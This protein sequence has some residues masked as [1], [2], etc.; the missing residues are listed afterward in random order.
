MTGPEESRYDERSEMLRVLR[1]RISTETDPE[2][3]KLLA[4]QCDRIVRDTVAKK[5]R[6]A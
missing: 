3:V 2:K 6:A 1:E 4:E 5:P